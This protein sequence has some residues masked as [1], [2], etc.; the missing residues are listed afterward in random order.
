[1]TFEPIKVAIADDHRTLRQS[2]RH[3][4]TLNALIKITIEASNGRELIAGITKDQPDVV[5]LDIKMPEMDGI[6]ALKII[7]HQFPHVRVLMLSA[8]LDEVY[9]TECLKFGI[10]GYLTKDMNISE[11]AKAIE[12]AYKNEVYFTNLLGNTYLKNYIFQH[13]KKGQL[14]MPEFSEEEVRILELILLEKTTEEVARTLCLS[15]RSIELKREKM[16]EKANVKTT[17]GL[18]LYCIKRGIIE[19][20]CSNEHH[21]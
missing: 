20:S 11:V 8:F 7:Y 3:T 18:I 16:K 9:V 14:S 10:N 13:N 12:L 5:L 21:T 4:L 2:L 1:M 19:M 15:K 17:T 6:Q